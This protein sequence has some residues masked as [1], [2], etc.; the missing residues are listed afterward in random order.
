MVISKVNT[1]LKKVNNFNYLGRFIGYTKLDI[2]VVIAKSF[3]AI[4]SMTK[5]GTQI[6]WI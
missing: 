1:V 6:Y 3:A 5:N 4:T 2:E